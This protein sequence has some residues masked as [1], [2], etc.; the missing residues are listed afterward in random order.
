MAGWAS[1][2]HTERDVGCSTR[3]VA[4]IFWSQHTD[5]NNDE[6]DGDDDDYDDDGMM[7]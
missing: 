5:D 4:N 6:D 1:R 3:C 7:M 2:V